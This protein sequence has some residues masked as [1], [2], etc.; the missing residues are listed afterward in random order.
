MIEE[1][2]AFRTEDGKTF[3]T[4]EDAEQHELHQAQDHGIAAYLAAA[5]PND[6]ARARS[7]AEAA[8]RRYLR[9]ELEHGTR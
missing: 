5:M 3:A 4:R 1:I 2:P 6:S 8:I 7:R 9:W